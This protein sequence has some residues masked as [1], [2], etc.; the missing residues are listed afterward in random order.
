MKRV[1]SCRGVLS[2][3]T[4]QGDSHAFLFHLLRFEGSEP[5]GRIHCG[6]KEFTCTGDET[7]RNEQRLRDS[8]AIT[9][10]LCFT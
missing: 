5:E 6:R 2:L 9:E 3:E 10:H 4:V 7:G 1:Q 8:D